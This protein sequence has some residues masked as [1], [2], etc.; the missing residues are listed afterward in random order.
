[1]LGTF[2]ILY[3]FLGGAAAAVLGTTAAWSL[4]F[5]GTRT[6]TP[7]QDCAFTAVRALSYRVGLVIL[8]GAALCLLMDLGRPEKAFLLFTRPTLS[9]LTVGSFVLVGC[10]AVAVLLV[11]TAT[12]SAPFAPSRAVKAL[13]GVCIVL[14]LAM[15]LY[16]GLYL[17]WL[18]AV[19]LWDNPVL[20]W[21]LAASSL[22][23]GLSVVLALSPFVRDW[24]QLGGWFDALHRLHGWV[25]VGVAVLFAAFLLVGWANP[26]ARSSLCALVGLNEGGWWLWAGF[27]VAGVAV[28]W[29]AERFASWL[30]APSPVIGAEALCLLGGLI[31]RFCLV[32]SGTH[33]LG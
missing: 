20:P 1:M 13:E 30:P 5:C 25:L 16:T 17:A 12:G 29:A 11:A 27:V 31:L 9:Y 28:P 24:R 7:E 14:A 22:S 18:Q 4:L 32:L 8:L 21:L 23:S 26:L 33:Y 3:L 2:V 10:M 6:R 15:M 19:P